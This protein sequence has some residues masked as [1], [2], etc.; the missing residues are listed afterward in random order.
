MIPAAAFL[1]IAEQ[2]RRLCLPEGNTPDTRR[3]I[4]KLVLHFAG[5]NLPDRRRIAEANLTA[6]DPKN[7]ETYALRCLAELTRVIREEERHQELLAKFDGI[8]K[9]NDQLKDIIA[10]LDPKAVADAQ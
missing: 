10:K 7:P 3:L 1:L 5:S 4:R 6:V 9:A 2:T 8:S